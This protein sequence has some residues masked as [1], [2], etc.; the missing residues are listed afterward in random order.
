MVYKNEKSISKANICHIYHTWY[1]LEEKTKTFGLWVTITFTMQEYIKHGKYLRN[2]SFV[3]NSNERKKL[4]R[5][6]TMYRPIS[7]EKH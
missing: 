4:L 3:N 7:E 1:G 2:I 5:Y 6:W